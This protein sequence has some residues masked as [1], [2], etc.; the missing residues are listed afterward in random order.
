[1]GKLLSAS[2]LAIAIVAISSAAVAAPPAA[3]HRFYVGLDVGRST[4]D[5][6]ISNQFFGQTV[7][8][9]AGDSTG[10]RLR[11]GYQF[12][13][14]VAMEGGYVDFG[15]FSVHD[16]P[17]TC[18]TGGGGAT[19]CTYDVRSK[20][21]GVFMDVVGSWPFAGR[22]TL[23]GRLGAIRAE[24]RTSER[25]PNLPASSRRYSDTNAGL[26]YGV[27]LAYSFNPRADAE[28]SWSEFDQLG[29]GLDIGGGAAVFDLGSSKL[30]SLGVRYRF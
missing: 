17:Y 29:L 15:E 24:S 27:G 22:W 11:F 30:L 1:M 18:S 25:D 14:Y 16:I 5:G 13:R 26:M 4:S 12:T 19:S 8:Q 28:L 6:E 7:R 2:G 20:T 9:P 23:N 21:R 10:A 3:P